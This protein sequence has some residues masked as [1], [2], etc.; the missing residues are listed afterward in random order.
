[1]SSIMLS[2]VRHSVRCASAPIL[3][4]FS[5]SKSALTTV[6]TKTPMSFSEIK[7]FSPSLIKE[8]VVPRE[9]FL[10]LL[11]FRNLGKAIDLLAHIGEAHH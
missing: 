2:Q 10:G 1:M 3:S 6:C 11:R 4:N 8:E 7:P 5:L 9:Q